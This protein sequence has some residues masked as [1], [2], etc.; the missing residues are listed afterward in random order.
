MEN[1]AEMVLA[2]DAC[3]DRLEYLNN[4]FPDLA[5]PTT[6]EGVIHWRQYRSRLPNLDIAGELPRET[7]HAIDLRSIAIGLL[8]Q[9]SLEDVL[10][11]LKEEQAVE[12]TLP[13][14]VQLIGRKD[15]LTVLKREFRELLKN[16]IS[17]EQI[18]A[19]WN[20]LERPAF[21]GATWN[22]RSVSML[23]N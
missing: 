7:Q 2:M 4:L 16:A 1:Y 19:L 6:T 5:T 3:A 10:E 20:D 13:E 15:Y 21:G 8:Q 17:F 23:A 18:A 12:L 11:M 22:S 9:H 14:L